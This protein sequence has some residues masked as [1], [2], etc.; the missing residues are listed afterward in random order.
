MALVQAIV[1]ISVLFLAAA[2]HRAHESE[3]SADMRMSLARRQ[4]SLAQQITKSAILSVGTPGSTGSSD[5]A[6]RDLA[7]QELKASLKEWEANRRELVDSK[8]YTSPLSKESAHILELADEHYL[9]IKSAADC[10]IRDRGQEPAATHDL[11][12]ILAAEPLFRSQLEAFAEQKEMAD[13]NADGL[14]QQVGWVVSAIILAMLFFLCRFLIRP[15]ARRLEQSFADIQGKTEVLEASNKEISR[16]KDELEDQNAKLAESE[17]IAI[18]EAVRA[19]DNFRI[20]E[21]AGRRFQELFHGL[22]VACFSISQD[23]LIHEWNRAAEDLFERQGHKVF[24]KKL[25]EVLPIFLSPDS[26][27][28]A[29]EIER[30]LKGRASIGKAYPLLTQSGETRW[31]MTRAFPFHCARGNIVGALCTA[32]DITQVK[33]SEMRLQIAEERTRNIV[34][35][36]G[37]AIITIDSSASILSFNSAAEKMFGYSS[38]EAIGQ[39]VSI[40]MPES[41]RGEHDSY[42]RRASKSDIASPL[43]GT[44]REVNGLRKDGTEFPVELSLSKGHAGQDIFFTGIVRDISER[45]ALEAQVHDQ[46]AEVNEMLIKM[47]MQTFELEEANRKLEALATIDGLTGLMNH[48]AF[49]ETLDEC[50]ADSRAGDELSMMLMDIDHFKSFNDTFG[51]Q[52]GDAVLKLV[53]KTV[54]SAVGD[55]GYVARYGGEEFAVILPGCGTHTAEEIAEKIRDAIESTDCEYRQITTSLGVAVWGR[56]TQHATD[57]IE[58]ADQALYAS[59]RSGRN[60]VSAWSAEMSEAA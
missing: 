39:N 34:E 47:E 54:Q 25:T 1:A 30:A 14:A 35:A 20:A 22:P 59:K 55:K 24:L 46:T 37:D 42:V 45:R 15:M 17:S 60:R 32:T 7:L 57:L 19:F 6:Q 4:C 48:R 43:I 53:A 29:S 12:A 40:L 16:L 56:D 52:A 11:P 33:E 23:G 26:D 41:L 38:E 27:G 2:T 31:I 3:R 51:H 10:L 8:K 21:H 18:E 5:Q 50:I 44:V 28:P 36:A 49:R 9:K 13:E 58:Q